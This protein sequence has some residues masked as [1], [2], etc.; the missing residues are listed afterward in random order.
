MHPARSFSEK[1]TPP[2]TSL[3]GDATQE[4]SSK[5]QPNTWLGH[6]EHARPPFTRCT[7]AFKLASTFWDVV[8]PRRAVSDRTFFR[9]S[10]CA[11]PKY[12]V[13]CGLSRARSNS[14]PTCG[15]SN[16]VGTRRLPT[17]RVLVN[18]L[19]QPR[20]SVGV[21]PVRRRKIKRIRSALRKPHALAIACILGRSGEVSIC[22]AC[23]TRKWHR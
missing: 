21:C 18:K 12:S 17:G 1:T 20:N 13:P 15:L 5:R 7:Q 11:E 22:L 14:R 3:W 8:S 9:Q 10:K 4:T 16:R 23:S 2:E 6:A 19:V